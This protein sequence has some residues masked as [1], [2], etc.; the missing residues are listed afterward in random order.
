MTAVMISRPSYSS[1][2]LARRLRV[3]RVVV[4]SRKTPT[5]SCVINWG[6]SE[7]PELRVSRFGTTLINHPAAVKEAVNKILTFKRLAAED[8]PVVDFTQDREVAAKWHKNGKSVYG[9]KFVCSRGGKGIDLF[10]AKKFQG[11]IPA[12]PLYTKFFP[13]ETE[14]RVHVVGGRVIDFAEKRRK[15]LLEPKPNRYWIRTHDN[16]WVFAREGA[17]LD[18]N[19]KDI[20]LRAIQ[21]LGLDFGA[22]DL[23]VNEDGECRVLEVNT[24]PGITG[25]TLNS[26]TRAFWNLL[27]SS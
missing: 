6:C 11:E 19:V 24:A 10:L 17:Q 15:R 21:A 1:R 2:Q 12:Y 22:V 23:R 25:S 27:H 13:C 18:E 14:Y 26:Y 20:S 4:G 9:R 16:G 7:I 3:R 5:A 8:V